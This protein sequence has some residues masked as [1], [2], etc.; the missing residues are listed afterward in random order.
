MSKLHYLDN[1]ATTRPAPEVVEA[2]M[3]FF[4]ERWGNASSMYEFVGRVHADKGGDISD[5]LE[6]LTESGMVARDGGANPATGAAARECPYRLKDNYS[7]FYLKYVEP[8]ADAIDADS[9]AFAG[10]E[11]F[12][13]WETDMGL[14]FENLVLNNF[15]ELLGL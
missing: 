11:Q 13:G 4:T 12:P 9:F 7:R 5:A 6:Q 10:L 1:N 14:Q 3:P 2:M 8:S 15:R